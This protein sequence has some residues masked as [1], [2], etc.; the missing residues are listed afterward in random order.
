VVANSSFEKLQPNSKVVIANSSKPATQSGS[1][2]TGTKP[3]GNK[4]TKSGNKATP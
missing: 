1:K 3:T 2:S 4:P